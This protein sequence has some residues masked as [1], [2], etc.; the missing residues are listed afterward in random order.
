MSGNMTLKYR[1]IHIIGGPGSGKTYASKKIQS[2]TNLTAYHLDDVFWNQSNGSYVRENET[3]RAEKLGK[4]LSNDS[5]VIEG[6]YY[7][8]LD[9]SFSN[10]DII[11]ILNPRFVKRQWRIFI[12]FLERK[13]LLGDFKKETF[14]SFMELSLWNKNFDS[15]N[16]LR[17]ESFISKHEDKI[18]YC[19]SFND[20]LCV[21]KAE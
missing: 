19:K 4:I 9:E 20:L 18:V 8:W 13:F 17:I 21:I 3:I 16:M 10:A 14:S 12:R 11:I 2:L 7:K 6:A 5:W 1:K 15:D